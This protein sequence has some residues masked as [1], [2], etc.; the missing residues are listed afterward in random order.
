MIINPQVPLHRLVMSLS[1]SLDHVS[2]SL[3]N[4]QLRVA[5]ISTRMARLMGYRGRQLR[6]IFHAGALHDIGLIRAEHRMRLAA[7]N[8][9]EGLDWHGEVGYQLLRDNEFFA[10]AAPLVRHHHIAWNDGR[11][12]EKNGQ[13][14][15]Q[16][17]HILALADYVDRYTRKDI[18]ILHQ[19]GDLTKRVVDARDKLLHPDCVDAF[20]SVSTREAFWLDAASPRI[21]SVLTDEID[22]PT[23]TIDE[24]AVE[25]IA[26]I[27]GRV[28]DGLSPWTATHSTGVAATAV[29]LAERMHFSPREVKL[30]RAAGYLHDLG[31]VSVPSEILDKQGKPTKAEWAVLK[32]HTYY[33]FRILETIGGMPQV[34]EWAAF[35]HERLDGKGYP[36]GHSARE[37]TLGARIMAVADTTTA[38]LEDRPYREGLSRQ[39]TIEILRKLVA[40]GALDGDVLDILLRDFDTISDIR[41]EKQAAYAI[42]QQDIAEALGSVPKQRQSTT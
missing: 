13:P 5:Y 4:H 31:K 3:T 39:K 1:E 28:A 14:V 24:D 18:P 36:F 33:T 20:L 10:D 22:W 30:M 37:L 29:A 35:H 17:S 40:D 26:H 21:Y 38:I 19:T 9:L 6:D 8:D 15:P 11:G 7:T 25:R 16:A 2:L 34:S 41:R 27:F 12:A 42:K 32:G 23:L